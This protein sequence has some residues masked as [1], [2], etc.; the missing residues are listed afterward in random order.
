[1]LRTASVIAAAIAASAALAACGGSS[2]TQ[3]TASGSRPSAAK[4]H[5]S[6]LQLAQC[7]R[8][9]GVPQFPDPGSS[10]AFGLQKGSGP[11][12]QNSISVDGHTLNVSAPAFQHAMQAC[13]KYQPKGPPLTSAQIAQLKQGALKMA[14]CMRRNGV[15][16]FPDPQVTTGPGGNGIA[17]RMGLGNTGGSQAAQLNPRSPA[18]QKAM[19]KCG[20][21]MQVGPKANGG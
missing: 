7:M 10:G 8:S 14:Q 18:F 5:S 13:H 15:P 17:V 12:G 20:A 6:A 11:G 2:P 1:M 16:N 3:T 19:N 21:L 9:H 4:L